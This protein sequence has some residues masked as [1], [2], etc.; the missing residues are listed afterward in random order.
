MGT[1]T[2]W[3]FTQLKNNTFAKFQGNMDGTRNY[4][5]VKVTQTQTDKYHTFFLIDPSM[6][7]PGSL[8]LFDSQDIVMVCWLSHGLACGFYV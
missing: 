4:Y 3:N 2:Q 5:I 6:S 7:Y 8:S 1:C